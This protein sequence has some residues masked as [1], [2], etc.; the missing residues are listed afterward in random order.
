ML[1]TWNQ[2]TKPNNQDF[3]LLL[4]FNLYKWIPC[5]IIYHFDVRPP[6]ADIRK[7]GRCIAGVW[8][9]DPNKQ[10][11]C[12]QIC[13][14]MLILYPFAPCDTI[15]SVIGVN[16]MWTSLRSGSLWLNTLPGV[17]PLQLP[18]WG[19]SIAWRGIG[20]CLSTTVAQRVNC[21][22]FPCWLQWC[23]TMPWE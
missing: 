5:W 3:Y 18:N 16:N 14:I 8:N 12:K 20:D 17:T 2:L 22:P 21:M 9:L 15:F 4:H 6:Y 1:L 11:K 23:Q 7:M 13:L 10:T 19:N